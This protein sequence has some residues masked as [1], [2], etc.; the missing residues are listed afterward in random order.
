MFTTHL[1]KDQTNACQG[2]CVRAVI[3]GRLKKH[4]PIFKGIAKW[5]TQV[6]LCHE[7]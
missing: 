1:T 6:E 7:N 4:A 2:V 5:C 3:M